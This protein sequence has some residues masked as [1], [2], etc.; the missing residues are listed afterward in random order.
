M[1]VRCA[2][3]YNI[4][5][6]K[7]G[8]WLGRVTSGHDL[9]SVAG[10]HGKTTTTAM[11]A[12]VLGSLCPEAEGGVTAIVGGDVAS[13]EDGG[14][15]V[16]EG[17]TFVLEADE[18]DRTF[19]GLRSRHA[20]V[21]NVELDHLDV[22]ESEEEILQAFEEFLENV[23]QSGA[24]VMCGDDLGCRA[25][26]ERREIGPEGGEEGAGPSVQT[27]G[28]GGGESF[29]PYLCASLD[30]YSDPFLFFRERLEGHGR[31]G[32]GRRR[33]LVQGGAAGRGHPRAV[34]PAPAGEAQRAERTRRHRSGGGG[35]AGGQVGPGVC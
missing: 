3:R 14:A 7:R 12:E 11:V 13:W 25:L 34:P 18:Y 24:V 29:L 33:D 31:Q 17:Q 6:Y 21:T 35:G 8:A 23:S 9:V 19:L 26:L 22:Y 16:G 4:P 15:V 10:T 28:Y 2:L 5:L 30:M 1:E 27:Y 32:G 20:I